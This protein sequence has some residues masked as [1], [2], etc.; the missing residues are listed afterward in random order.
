M[1][2][3]ADTLARASHL[4][5]S[6][7]FAEAE[8]LCRE[9]LRSAPQTHSAYRLLGLS[10]L[11]RNEPKEAIKF[12]RSA[13]EL[14]PS[15]AEYHDLLGTAYRELGE[16]KE[17][18]IC[19]QNAIRL[20][21]TRAGFHNN[22]GAALFDQGL[23]SD[24]IV[25]HERALE[26]DSQLATAHYNLGNALQAQHQLG[27]AI[28]CYERALQIDPN[29]GRAHANLGAARFAQNDL[30]RAHRHYATAL[31]L[32]P[33][34][35]EI[36]NN[37]GSVKYHQGDQKA[38]I[39][40]YR[41][42]IRLQRDYADAI[43]NLAESLHE[44]GDFGSAI[45]CY[46]RLCDLTPDNAAAFNNLGVSLHYAC[47]IEEAIASYEKAIV[48]NPG[49][50]EA[51][52]NLGRAFRDTN[53]LTRAEL[54][55]RKSV[56]LNSD[57]VEAF[58]G[59]ASVLDDAQRYD[60][61][62]VY[63]D[64]AVKMAPD[65]AEARFS[66]SL[67]LLRQ[68]DFNRGW[69]EYEW[70]WQTKQLQTRKLPVE[71]WQGDPLLGRTVLIHAEQGL[72]DTIQFA[73]YLPMVKERG[74]T[75]IL[76]CDERLRLLLKR[77]E[78]VDQIVS[79]GRP[80]PQFDVHAPLLSLPHLFHTSLLNIPGTKPYL[81]A[82]DQL[83]VQ[84]QKCLFEH[85]GFRVGVCWQGNSNHRRDVFRSIPREHFSSLLNVDNVKL[86]SLQYRSEPTLV[87]IPSSD[88]II[89]L[90]KS[91]DVRSGPFMDTAAVIENL[92]LVISCDT[93]VAHLAGALGVPVWLALDHAADWRWMQGRTDSPWYPTM[94]L[95]RQ[96]SPGDWEGV[97][98]TMCD[99]LRQEV[100]DRRL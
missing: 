39:S 74:G 55:Y 18:V 45:E 77:V 8:S 4:Y 56:A 28:S 48:L 73:R 87:D 12:V 11:A 47:R 15:S 95:F 60:E 58:A 17:A 9:L 1:L 3:I 6:G 20:D 80:M 89:D 98:N 22:L 96:E 85:R 76:A 26:L 29:H 88:R 63:F 79:L 61:A 19:Y 100:A 2:P 54:A 43:A 93:A 53:D 10:A 33:C 62:M 51:F 16:F 25:C 94:R 91:L 31:A 86:I 82:D 92:D 14:D 66:R 49:Y 83:T 44:R 52:N 65:N 35:P 71:L 59:L 7:D 38:A 23:L 13:L 41:E 50:A 42:A 27:P 75:V 46:E 24:A 84:W 99:S 97:F 34:S 57:L 30:E 32:L 72:G 37:L 40:L 81:T 5:A 36:H 64:H 67:A 70:R 69:R 68:G 90:S 21:S 78:G